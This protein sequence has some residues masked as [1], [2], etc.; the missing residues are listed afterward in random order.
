[1]PDQVQ[2]NKSPAISTHIA[3]E[4]DQILFA[5]MM[6]EIHAECHVSSRERIE[7]CI[8]TNDRHRHSDGWT[9]LNVRSHYIKAQLSA[10]LLD[11]QTGSASYIQNTADRRRISL[12]R[13]SNGPHIAKPAVNSGNVTVCV[14]DQ[15][16]GQVHAIK[17]LC[18][19]A[20]NHLLNYQP[21][22]GVLPS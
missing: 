8:R 11:Y 14:L 10:H 19:I 1:V 18:L 22:G 3:D 6:A 12:D 7:T 13:L 4:A 17:Y 15:L 16:I 2:Q 9:R 20:A 5:E 21:A